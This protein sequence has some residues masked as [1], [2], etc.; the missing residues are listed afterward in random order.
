MSRGRLVD[1]VPASE[2]SNER[3]GTLMA[4]IGPDRV[5]PVSIAPAP[6]LTTA[7]DS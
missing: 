6:D 2:A 7:L 5:D 3:L 1:T 4:G